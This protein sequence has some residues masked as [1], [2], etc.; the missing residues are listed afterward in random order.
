MGWFDFLRRKLGKQPASPKS[1]SKKKTRVAVA[2]TTVQKRPRQKPKLE[3][4]I[5]SEWSTSL[6]NLQ[7]HPLTQAKI[8]NERLLAAVIE[9]LNE[10][11]TKLDELSL[12]VNK[13]ETQKTIKEQ[14]KPKV[15][16]SQ[17]EQKVIDYVKKKKLV[18]ASEVAESLKISR[19]NAAL[20]LS[21]LF[22][23]G[24]LEKEQEGKI[25]YYKIA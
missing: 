25:V 2:T 7:K 22:S 14:E 16:L 6:R 12:R 15:K 9:A 18:Q 19:P 21:K 20:K 8:L 17:G 1:E 24:L 11:N 4:A 5:L 10:I 13:L 3:H 23:I